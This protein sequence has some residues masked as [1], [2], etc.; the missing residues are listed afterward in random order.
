MDLI[1]VCV[2]LGAAV[3][4]LLAW[5]LS[6]IFR[7]RRLQRALDARDTHPGYRLSVVVRNPRQLARQRAPLGGRVAAI[8]PGFVT[9]RVYE[10]LARELDD[11]LSARGVEVEIE[12]H[13]R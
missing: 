7:L 13:E 12:I 4:G 8:A 2:A 3:A 6:L 9:R 11:E 10:V 5:A 1:W